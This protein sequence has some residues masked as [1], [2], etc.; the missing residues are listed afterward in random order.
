MN[1]HH[2][3]ILMTRF[4]ENDFSK[5]LIL[6][7]QRWFTDEHDKSLKD[8]V[9]NELWE[10]E[11]AE[12][13]Q[14]TLQGLE[15][16]NRR[17]GKTKNPVRISLPRRLLR[18][19]SIFLL[20]IISALLTYW[21]MQDKNEPSALTAEMVEYIVPDG[22]I[23]QILLPDSSKV[24]LNAGSMLLFPESFSGTDRRLFLSGEATF[25]VTKDPGRPFIVRTQYMQV[26]AFGTTFNV[27]SYVDAGITAVTLEEG[28]VRVDVDGKVSASEL[29]RPDEQFV[30]DHRRGKTVKLQ[31]DA[32]L[33]VKWKEGYLVF[34]DA[35]F[36]D[37]IRTV[38]RRFN[39]TVHYDIRKY[40]GGSFSVKYRPYEDVEQV[41]AILETLNPGLKWTIEGDIIHIK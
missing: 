31:V 7:F 29:I 22:E 13:D 2:I 6:K 11:T 8:E 3:R 1:K 26:E 35:S 40:G 15:E 20:P 14:C 36:E 41:L 34:E 9:L 28:S 38:E 33:V 25:K 37:I 23:K 4:F 16:M 12:A 5:E 30:Y 24:W 19:A 18:I 21:I 17:I 10:Q 27:K 39:V 32:E